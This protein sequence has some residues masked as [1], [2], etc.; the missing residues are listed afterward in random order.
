MIWVETARLDSQ[1]YQYLYREG[2]QQHCHG[3]GLARLRTA[4]HYDNDWVESV[5]LVVCR[6]QC[7]LIALS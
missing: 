4:L 6:L 3:V 2:A 5:R 1:A 7:S